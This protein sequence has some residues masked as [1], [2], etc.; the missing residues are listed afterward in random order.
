M[1]LTLGE[2]IKKLRTDLDLSLDKAATMAELSKSYLWELEN[3]RAGKKPIKPSAEI[4]TRLAGVLKVT[5]EFLLDEKQ[6][7]PKNE[8][9]REAFFRKFSQLDAEDQ[10]KFEEM[11][12][13]WGKKK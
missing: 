6:A 12:D 13:L 7:E 9:L 10:K 11:I 5:A 1:S 4:L 2:K 3:P 8:V